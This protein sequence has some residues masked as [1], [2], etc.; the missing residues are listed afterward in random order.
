VSLPFTVS[1][2]TVWSPAYVP[3]GTLFPAN[4]EIVVVL[5][6]LYVPPEDPE[7]LRNSLPEFARPAFT[8]RRG[9]RRCAGHILEDVTWPDPPHFH[10]HWRCMVCAKTWKRVRPRAVARARAELEWADDFQWGIITW[11]DEMDIKAGKRSP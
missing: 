7:Y 3:R 1:S 9:K 8:Y 10:L 11:I 4:G 2:V 6:D 5:V